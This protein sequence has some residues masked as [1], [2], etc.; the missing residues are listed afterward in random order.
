MTPALQSS[1]IP[2]ELSS[3][4]E[5][6]FVQPGHVL[7]PLR[8]LSS[9]STPDVTPH[10]TSVLGAGITTSTSTGVS[11]RERDGTHGMNPVMATGIS[12]HEQQSEPSTHDIAEP[13][14]EC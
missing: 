3:S 4:V 7:Q 10:V 14:G 13:P 9:S 5:P 11:A 8:S 2:T 6:A 12:L 1:V